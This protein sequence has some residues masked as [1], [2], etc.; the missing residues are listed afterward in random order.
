MRFP[1]NT[2]VQNEEN[3]KMR[4]EKFFH[5]AVLPAAKTAEKIICILLFAATAPLLTAANPLFK[6]DFDNGCNAEFAKGD[7]APFAVADKL[8]ML[9]DG[10]SGKA[11]RIGHWE[12][13]LT[14]GTTD[15]RQRKYSYVYK[16]ENN[17]NHLKGSISFWVA[18]GDWDGSST[19]PMRVF[20]SAD[21]NGNSM[22][23]YKI[24]N[25]PYL[26]FYIKNQKAV[27]CSLDLKNWKKG[28]WHFIVCNWD[29]GFMSLFVDGKLIKSA[30]YKPFEKPFRNLRIGS[31]LSKIEEGG[32][33][34]DEFRVYDGPLSPDEVAKAFQRNDEKNAEPSAAEAIKGISMKVGCS[35]PVLDGVIKAG[36]YAMGGTG[37]IE[38][39]SRG[40]SPNQTRYYL[41]HDSEKLY[42]AVQTAKGNA[43]AG[44]YKGRDEALWE[45]EEIEFYILTAQDELY[46]FIFNSSDTIYD[47]KNRNT[48]WNSKNIR[49]KSRL[50]DELWTLEGE[51][52]WTD[53]LDAKPEKIKFNFCRT[54]QSPYL[55]T[56]LANVG[57]VGYAN[58]AM[59]AEAYFVA[60]APKFDLSKIGNL[61]QR[62]LDLRSTV[63][64]GTGSVT[65]T[66]KGL[67]ANR[68]L[69]EKKKQEKLSVS[70]KKLN[71]SQKDFSDSNSV[72]ITL[73][74]E[75]YGTL[76]QSDFK[77]SAAESMKMQ[78]IYT[79]IDKKQVV[80]VVT[81]STPPKYRG[82][83]NVVFTDETGKKALVKDFSLDY[84]RTTMKLTADIDGLKPGFYKI[85][86]K[87][88]LP[89]GSENQVFLEEWRKPESPASWEKKPFVLKPGV[90]EGWTPLEVKNDSHI[91]CVGRTYE[92][93]HSLLLSQFTTLGKKYLTSPMI[94]TIN[95]DSEIKDFRKSAIVN[96]GEKAEIVRTGTIGNVQIVS[97]MTMEFDGLLNVKLTLKPLS[98]TSNID[99]MTLEMPFQKQYALY[100]NG[101]KSWNNVNSGPTRFFTDKP[102]YSNLFQNFH[103]WLGD[104]DTGFTFLAENLRNWHCRNMDQSVKIGLDQAGSRRAVFNI[105]DSPL[106]LEKERTIEFAVMLTP[107]RNLDVSVNRYQAKDWEMWSGAYYRYFDYQYPGYAIRKPGNSRLFHYSTLTGTS[108]HSPDWNYWTERWVFNAGALG[109]V[110][111]DFPAKNLEARNR[112]HY[113]MACL[114]AKSFLDFKTEQAQFAV[115][116]HDIHNYYFD[117]GTLLPCANELHGCKWIDDFGRE[118]RSF[119]WKN[120]R[121][122]IRRISQILHKKHPE[123]LISVHTNVQRIAPVLSFVDICVGGEDFVPEVGARGN[124]YDI[125]NSEV[126]RCYSLPLGLVTKNIFIP[127]FARALQFVNPGKIFDGSKPENQHAMRHLMTLLLAHNYDVFGGH[128]YY[129]FKT[130]F[131]WDCDTKFIPYWN[132]Q[133]C[134]KIE[135]S[136]NGKIVLSAF[137]RPEGRVALVMVNDCNASEN[138]VL[139]LDCQKLFGKDSP[140]SVKDV[141]FPEKQYTFRDGAVSMS[142]SPREGR[143]LILE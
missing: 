29:N 98:G 127:Q 109:M 1:T 52:P 40:F 17:I 5:T 41:S 119:P 105:V 81:T 64:N 130:S 63:G 100:C 54:F 73:D 91:S 72:I 32:S 140:V 104:E 85:T 68:T 135:N 124:Y 94:I 107:S 60:D 141:Y 46:Q 14:P 19:K 21:G 38:R 61:A 74:S 99:K 132:H 42:F 142:L 16:A 117:L 93:D 96:H 136:K 106:K 115:D 4:R 45:N 34:L 97:Q 22:M 25:A 80:F 36:E 78:F 120:A 138:I 122:F 101:G 102:W 88:R 67:A 53:I 24:Y 56:S 26:Y 8:E 92:F 95:G 12:G 112:S 44:D 103:F 37:F 89:D 134:W 82:T 18:S 137:T 9:T 113:I 128:P 123:A 139:K 129:K 58:K 114:N 116:Y 30:E 125:V 84:P 11:L 71:I 50:D 121:T 33:L 51:L 27:S 23:I 90:P 15:V 47:N 87:Q 118:Q 7:A 55:Q 6:A 133:D 57:P 126:L 110:Y 108:P 28:E 35:K 31:Q 86:G 70:S 39:A 76:Y 13:I 77:L 131:G 10:I 69:F 79:E 66:A 49:V 83:L 143:I 20:V 48:A 43:P 111:A 59:F 62:E 65:L 2:K 75:K 3:V